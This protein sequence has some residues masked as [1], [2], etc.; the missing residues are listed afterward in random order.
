MMISHPISLLRAK[1]MFFTA[2]VLIATVCRAEEE[3]AIDRDNITITQSVRIKPGSYCI[4]DTDNNGVLQIKSDNIIVDFQGATLTAMNLNHPD[5]TEAEDTGISIN[6]ARNVTIRNANVHGYHFNIHAI[7][8]PELKLEGCNVSYSHA[9]RIAADGKPVEIWIHLR[10]LQAWRDYG[11]GILI[12]NSD[13]SVIHD[14]T[15]SGAQNGL[16]LVNSSDC[17]I[18]SCDFSYNSGFGVALWKSCRNIIAW[19]MI[20]FVNR[21]WGGGWGGDSAALVTVNECH[22]NYL[23]GNSLTHSGDGLFLTDITKS[24]IDRK[25]QTYTCEGS[26]NNNVIAY[27]DGSWSPH[28]AFE[29]TFSRGNIYYR[30]IASDSDYGFWL[31]YSSDSALFENEIS[32]I[33]REGIAIEQGSGTRID[34]NTFTQTQGAAIAHWSAGGLIGTLR[35]S[36]DIIIRNNRIKD[37]AMAYRLDNST[38]VLIS[39]NIITK[40]TKHDFEPLEQP[41][42][43]ELAD[44][45]ASIKYEKLQQILKEKPR[46]FVMLRDRPGPK[47][48]M[49]LQAGEFSP[50][51]QRGRLVA[52]HRK[53]E[54]T[55]EIVPLVPDK[56]T[57]TKPDWIS[58]TRDAQSDSYTVSM[59]PTT[60][61]WGIVEYT[62]E[63]HDEATNKTQTISGTFKNIQWDLRWHRWDLPVRLAYDDAAAWKKLFNSEPIH[64]QTSHEVSS[65]LWATGFPQGVPREYFAIVAETKVRLP[66]GRYRFSTISDDGIRV[67]LDGKEVISRWNH[68]G[69]TPDETE[70]TI[71]GDVHRIVIHYCQ[72]DGY[73]ELAFDLQRIDDKESLN[74]SSDRDQPSSR[75]TSKD[76]PATEVEQLTVNP[77]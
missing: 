74:A 5:L 10:S 20:D 75:P 70:V 18:K 57:F 29:G 23:V 11:A 40:T 16:L 19:N 4:K 34:G 56:L 52:W 2:L 69:P 31:G 47:G 46:D 17:T 55:L 77:C 27:N 44:F 59:K 28:N 68:H 26:C 41:P 72:A 13:Q 42:S 15:G 37:C 35:P 14:C 45:K 43:Q 73:L 3:M 51:D 8:A 58:I 64:R 67:F 30:N 66:G 7:N 76:L 62:I 9:Q 1:P 61:V 63:I 60:E 6:A 33:N 54:D 25:S 12:E 48:T 53:D 24:H 32:R 36:R 38:D 65:T 71:T 49:T 21:P 50:L 22:D 39:G